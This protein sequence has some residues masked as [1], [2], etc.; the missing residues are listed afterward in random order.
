MDRPPAIPALIAALSSPNPETRRLAAVALGRIQNEAAIPALVEALWDSES[1]VRQ[2]ASTALNEI[3]KLH[4]AYSSPPPPGTPHPINPELQQQIFQL[5][6]QRA[7]A[8][9][10]PGQLLFN[11]PTQMTLGVGERITVRIGRGALEGDLTRDLRGRG[12]AQIENIKVGTLIRAELSGPDFQTS[13]INGDRDRIIPEG[14]MQEW[15]FHVLPLKA[16]PRRML[17]LLVSI[18]IHL[19]TSEEFQGSQGLLRAQYPA[20]EELYSFPSFHREIAVD[21]NLKF[22][23]TRFLDENW[24][25][26]AGGFGAVAVSLIGFF[27]KRWLDS[28]APRQPPRG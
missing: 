17:D 26:F 21:V 2:A 8:E 4:I 3:P 7:M 23:V 18:R 19:P 28:R 5:A 13:L 1:M 20:K 6:I 12:L 22:Y 27:G 16:G 24:K 10:T 11:P 25:F 9:R 14:D 15:Q